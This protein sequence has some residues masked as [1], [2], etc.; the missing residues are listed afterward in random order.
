MFFGCEKILIPLL[1]AG[2]L[3][4]ISALIVL[5]TILAIVI[6]VYSSW[7]FM[8]IG[9]KTKQRN[10]GLAWIPIVGPLIITSQAAKMHWWP[11]LLLAGAWIPIVGSLLSIVVIV[12]SVIWLWK[13]FE[14]IKR[15]GWWALLCLIP[16][17][18]LVL[19]GIAAWGK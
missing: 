14:A 15:P 4:L 18:N 5:W 10:Y 12:F 8:A 3:A 2:T 16:I 6:Y 1:G 17:V 11:I 7:A 9:K 13:T 19:I